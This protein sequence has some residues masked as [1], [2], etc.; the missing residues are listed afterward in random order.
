MLQSHRTLCLLALEAPSH[1]RTNLAIHILFPTISSSPPRLRCI[2]I[3]R[4]IY[5]SSVSTLRGT[6]T[7]SCCETTHAAL[8]DCLAVSNVLCSL[9]SSLSLSSCSV[10]GFARVDCGLGVAELAAGFLVRNLIDVGC[11]VPIETHRSDEAN[12]RLYAM[13]ALLCLLP[14]FL[15]VHQVG[16]HDVELVAMIWNRD[17]SCNF[18][19]LLL[20][21]LQVENFGR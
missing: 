12:L 4:L 18:V 11:F 15:G 14:A 13:K 2:S 17:G 6:A 20:V 16:R 8:T 10:V 5:E 3:F 21:C 7:L 19:A 9:L 1:S